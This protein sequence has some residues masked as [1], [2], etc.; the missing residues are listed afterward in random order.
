ML[1][2]KRLS[3]IIAI[4]ICILMLPG[5]E[6]INSFL[7]QEEP[8]ENE[9]ELS[10]MSFNMKFESL[11]G[12]EDPIHTW[13]RRKNGIVDCLNNYG[14]DIVGTQEL[15]CW[16]YEELMGLLGES[17][18]GVGLPRYNT[19]SERCSIIYNTETIEYLEGETIWLSETPDVVG[20]KS[21]GSAQPRILTYG[22]FLHK[23]TQTE[24]YFFNTHLDHK[25]AEAR[26][27]QLKMVVSYMDKY[28]GD[29][30]VILTGDF[31][32]YLSNEAF[33]PL[34]SRTDVYDNTFTPFLDE[35]GENMKTTHG[36]NGG[37]SGSPIDF[38]FYSIDDL[39][40]NSTQI[41]HDVYQNRYYLSDH[42]PVHS[43]FTFK[44]NEE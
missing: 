14:A 16:Q 35:L 12:S 2:I 9:M 28:L 31:N 11:T 27:N 42:Y 29:Y 43:I 20:S 26:A 34:T 4:C 24:F 1:L 32:I 5:C 22:K 8:D 7:P 15:Q 19:N 39:T 6:L 38:I 17:W 40:V 44:N 23:A 18:A 10:V 30:P 36:F 13:A 33:E 25:S 21:W 3:A 37:I 41:I